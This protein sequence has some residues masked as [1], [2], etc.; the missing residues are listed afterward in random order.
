VRERTGE[1]AVLKTL[2][3]SDARV[4]AM[5]LGESLLIS[6]LGAAIGL[7]LGS[8]FVTGAASSMAQFPGLALSGGTLGLGLILAVLL[9]LITGAWPAWQAGRLRV[10]EALGRR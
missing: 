1:L 7:A 3:F 4:I 9:G 2:G 5:V 10:V 6:V 8:V